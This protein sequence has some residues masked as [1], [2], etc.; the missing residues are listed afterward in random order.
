M[1]NVNIAALIRS[2]SPE[3]QALGKDL[4]DIEVKTSANPNLIIDTTKERQAVYQSLKG[5]RLSLFE[6]L[7]QACS[8]GEPQEPKDYR[9]KTVYGPSFSRLFQVGVA[10]AEAQTAC[11]NHK[12]MLATQDNVIVSAKCTQPAASTFSYEI[13]YRARKEG[14]PR[15]LYGPVTSRLFLS[16]VSYQE[17]ATNLQNEKRSLSEKGKMIE[18]A[19]VLEI[20]SGLGIYSY[21]I[22]YS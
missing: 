12:R 10:Q 17:S 4:L 19:E 20:R 8:T 21:K 7:M 1:Q 15:D 5:D 2:S 14:E 13:E 22:T 3:E 16:G 9:V 6:D 18:S 11:H